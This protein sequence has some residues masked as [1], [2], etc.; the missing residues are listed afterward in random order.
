MPNDTTVCKFRH[1]LEAHSLGD[2]LFAL[3][4]EYLQEKGIQVNTGTIVDAASND[5]P[6]STKN[7]E[8]A[9]ELQMHQTKKGN[10]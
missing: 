2:R 9:R 3:K 4:G 7:K 8:K 6:S 10:Q 1:L 5:A